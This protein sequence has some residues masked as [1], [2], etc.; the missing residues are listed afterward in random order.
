MSAA[1]PLFSARAESEMRAQIRVLLAS[2][3]TV[4]PIGRYTHIRM[5]GAETLHEFP[6]A[7]VVDEQ[8][9]RLA[10][11]ERRLGP[12]LPDEPVSLGP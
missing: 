10:A 1:R 9:I 5:P 8:R 6:S 12:D 7:L 3:A 4:T 11:V 2:G